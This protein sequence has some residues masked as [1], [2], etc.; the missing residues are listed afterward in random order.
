MQK[1]SI[2]IDGKRY[3]AYHTMGAILRFK[4]ETGKEVSEIDANAVSEQ[5]ICCWCCVRSACRREGV[6]FNYSL[7]D[8]ADRMSFE[9]VVDWAAQIG[10]SITPAIVQTESTKKK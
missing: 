1:V 5:V 4:Q 2:K 10:E 3:P 7:E 8:F 6:E 9:D